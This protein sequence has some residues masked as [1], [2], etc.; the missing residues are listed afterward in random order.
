MTLIGRAKRILESRLPPGSLR[1][2]FVRGAFWS[3]VGT[4]GAQGLS[5]LAVIVAGRV[6]GKSR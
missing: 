1:G 5:L 3:M 4:V 2:R 6:L